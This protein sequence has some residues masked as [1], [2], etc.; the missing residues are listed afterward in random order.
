MYLAAL[1]C[2]NEAA[3]IN[4]SSP[5]LHRQ[6][7]HFSRISKSI[8]LKLGN[9]ADVLVT[10]AKIPDAVKSAIEKAFDLIPS[11]T[12]PADLNRSFISSAPT[13][14][15][16]ILAGAQSAIE[17][18]TAASAE[19]V[20]SILSK[21]VQ[22]DVPASVEQ[23][24]L[25]IEVLKQAGAEDEQVK[26]FRSKCRRRLPLAWVFASDEERASRKLEQGADGVAVN[27]E[28]TDV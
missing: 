19:D 2:L 5:V 17:L 20:E 22:A 16:H 3:A 24:T 8:A 9:R 25:A 1:K 4:R 27:G 28:K 26:E 13:S 23:L 10:T 14:A 12:T 18:S 7:I 11:S 6:I 21:I 15:A